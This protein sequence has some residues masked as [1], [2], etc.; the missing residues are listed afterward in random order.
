MNFLL[1]IHHG[2][3]PSNVQDCFKHARVSCTLLLLYEVDSRKPLLLQ[4]THSSDPCQY[5]E[6]ISGLRGSQDYGIRAVVTCSG[7]SEFPASCPSHFPVAQQGNCLQRQILFAR[8][9]KRR[10]CRTV[11]PRNKNERSNDLEK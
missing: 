7:A 10:H 9:Q 6:R 4:N 2:V 1:T 11:I 3:Y 5:P 8:T